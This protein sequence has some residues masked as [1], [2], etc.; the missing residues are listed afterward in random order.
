[1]TLN[2]YLYKNGLFFLPP[3]FSYGY[4]SNQ[5]D[6]S[7]Y[8][9]KPR[10][11][12]YP[13]S[14]N[15]IPAISPY[16]HQQHHQHYIQS[17]P[18][19]QDYSQRQQLHT[20]VEIQRSHGYEIKPEDTEYK[21][22]FEE[23]EYAQQGYQNAGYANHGSPVI[24]LR[25]PGPAKY[26]HHL[27]ALL[28]QYLEIR[29]A[30]YIQALQEQ[31]AR[32]LSSHHSG[33]YDEQEVSSYHPQPHNGHTY[34]AP[35]YGPAQYQPQ[36]QL[37]QQHE[38]QH[39]Q[40]QTYS[41]PEVQQVEEEAASP[42]DHSHEEHQ[43]AYQQQEE[44]GHEQQYQTEYENAY[45]PEQKQ[46]DESEA[47]PQPYAYEHPTPEDAA[48][49]QHLL[50]TE[51]FPSSKHTQVIFKS[52][53]Q[54]PH[55]Y[56]HHHEHEHE[57]EHEHSHTSATGS[58]SGDTSAQVQTYSAPLVYHQLEQ[59]YGDEQEFLPSS[60]PHG[61]YSQVHSHAEQSSEQNYVTITQRPHAAHAAPYNYH[62]H[63]S[64]DDAEYATPSPLRAR[65]AKRMAQFSEEQVKKFNALMNRMKKKMT[66]IQADEAANKDN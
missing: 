34:P 56:H 5:N 33:H 58:D 41:Q 1:M 28:Q 40:Q 23:N 65:S 8:F 63:P 22:I 59:Y 24:V 47:Q 32:S 53:T 6:N 57:H 17:N 11:Q 46:T 60:G 38:Q 20:T 25:I 29:A 61:S 36:Q 43:I 55:E 9:S 35:V 31:E 19:A 42:H 54:Q 3:N 2:C 66:A 62:A 39:E 12:V 27:Q 10:Y 13:Y 48:E 18:R 15:D 21:T 26:A 7:Y 64:S 16:Q 44:V 14:Q 45:Q 51:N 50:T 37:E 49:Q 4:Y 30:Q 52:T